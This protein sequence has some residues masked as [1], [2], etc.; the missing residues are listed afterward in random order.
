MDQNSSKMEALSAQKIITNAV[1][2]KQ[3]HYQVSGKKYINLS[4]GVL[5]SAESNGV[6]S[7]F[8]I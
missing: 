7:Y 2:D 4:G 6:N 8:Y 5:I 1:V 3:N